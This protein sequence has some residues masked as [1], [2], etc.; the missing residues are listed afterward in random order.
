MTQRHN[1][2]GFVLGFFKRFLTNSNATLCGGVVVKKNYVVFVLLCFLCSY[3]SMCFK[4]Y[5]VK[6]HHFCQ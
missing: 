4:N 2:K 5:V 1:E 6:K 3:V